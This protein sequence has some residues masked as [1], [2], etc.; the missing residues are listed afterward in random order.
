MTFRVIRLLSGG[1]GWNPVAELMV[2]SDGLLYGTTQFGGTFGGQGGVVF[3]INTNGSN[4]AVLHSFAY[5]V[6]PEGSRPTGGLV[7]GADGKL[8]GVTP[9][10]GTAQDGVIF[11]VDPSVQT[12]H[13]PTFT[14]LLPDQTLWILS[15]FNYVIPSSAVF[16]ADW[17]Q[18]NT[19]SV[20][21]LPA[22]ISFDPPTRAFSGIASNAGVFEITVTATDNGSPPA[23]A[24]TQF[25]LTVLQPD[26][27]VSHDGTNV[28][29]NWPAPI[30]RFIIEE[31]PSSARMR[32]GRMSRDLGAMSLAIAHI[33][34]FPP[35]PAR[36]FT[37]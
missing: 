29:F 31:S 37:A 25:R 11:R 10:G 13:P 23:S 22:G 15:S 5:P 27:Q 32:R 26:L 30:Y 2:R 33:S 3:Q 16:D 8:Y 28:M 20:A 36:G 6:G 24:T 35:N 18:T 34:P 9:L 19:Y 7:E 14:T 12:N 4:F 17:N 21:G 1:D